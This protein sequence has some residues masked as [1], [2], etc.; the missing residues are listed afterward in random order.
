MDFR[1]GQVQFGKEKAIFGFRLMDYGKG[2]QEN[3]KFLLFLYLS[4]FTN[5][6][7]PLPKSFW[8]A[9]VHITVKH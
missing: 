7:P 2:M 1:Y 3:G 5:P 4:H 6:T 8:F 9:F